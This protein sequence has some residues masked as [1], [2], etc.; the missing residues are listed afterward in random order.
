M[1]QEVTVF[2]DN[3]NDLGTF[4][5]GVYKVVV[6]N[7]HPDIRMLPDLIVQSNDE[8]GVAR[9]IERRLQADN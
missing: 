7:A 6:A 8:D 1:R 5:A 3:L 9:Y 4:N 2:G